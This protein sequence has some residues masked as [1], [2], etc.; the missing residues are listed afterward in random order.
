MNN[1]DHI[2]A[3]S[4]NANSTETAAQATAPQ[5]SI[6]SKAYP[7]SEMLHVDKRVYVLDEMQSDKF[8]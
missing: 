1:H 4:D 7:I 3:H 2:C 6:N 5:D 8:N